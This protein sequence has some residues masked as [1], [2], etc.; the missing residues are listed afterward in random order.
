MN[1]K[2]FQQMKSQGK[3]SQSAINQ[4][5]A[6]LE[7][8]PRRVQ[9]PIFKTAAAVFAVAS[10]A[11][12]I[13][14]FAFG[15]M[16]PGVPAPETTYPAPPG[17]SGSK[18]VS[19]VSVDLM[20][21]ITAKP[22]QGKT[23]DERFINSAAD[24]SVELF[25]RGITENENSL[26]SPLSVLLALS[27]TENGAAADTLREM[28]TAVGRGIA[29]DEM[30]K[31]LSQYLRGLLSTDEAK[32]SIANSIW[33]RDDEFL[34]VEENFLQKNANYYNAAAY[35]SDFNSP[36]TLADINGW[37]EE[38]TDKM[39]DKIIDEIDPNTVMYLINAIAFDALWE[40]PYATSN[41]REGEFTSWNNQKSTVEFMYSSENDFIQS[42]D[43]KGFIKKYKGGQYEFVAM[44]PNEDIAL[45]D[46][47]QSLTGE[48]F[49]SL[50]NSASD[51]W[52]MTGLPKFSYEYNKNLNDVLKDMGMPAAF[53][54]GNADFSKLGHSDRGNIYIGNVLHKTF[55]EVSEL[56]TKA[57]AVTAVAPAYGAAFGESVI[58]DR[59]FVYAIV[60]ANTKLPIFIGT[61]TTLG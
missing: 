12:C 18:P 44:L 39:I 3:P 19:S 16:K 32:L 58:L 10:A 26:L 33:F 40:T 57:G 36:K 54:S 21:S 61:V 24:F 51:D 7:T 47:I 4:L 45:N 60:D 8:Q 55:I 37:V 20:K 2:F 34:T 6:R 46:Y 13:W 25:K 9:K 27:M 50:L 15:P 29:V 53:D 41:V 17:S 11:V 38:N 23:A 14:L 5:K 49:I 1:K 35:K 52:V 56:G 48:K 30:N 28:K 31:Y 42:D 22:S 43:A 59:P